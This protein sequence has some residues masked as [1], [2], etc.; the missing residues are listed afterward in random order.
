M[1]ERRRKPGRKYTEQIGEAP[2]IQMRDHQT[3]ITRATPT[4]PNFMR[5]IAALLFLAALP[6][7]AQTNTGELRLK[8]T[9][10]SGLG[11]KTTVAIVSEANQYKNS[12]PTSEQGPLDVQRLPF[13]VYELSVNPTGFAAAT[14]TVEIRST[15]ATDFGLQLKLP[16][17]EQSVTVSTPETLVDPDQ[18]GAVSQIGSDTVQHRVSSLPG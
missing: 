2:N 1:P 16:Q 10:P 17:V 14:A 4:M 15:I 3:F 5:R 7:W 8:V 18:P 9:D 12:L 6:V 11:V 13:G